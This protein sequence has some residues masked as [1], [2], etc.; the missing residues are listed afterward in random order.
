MAGSNVINKRIFNSCPKE[1]D[2]VWDKK[3]NIRK[4]TFKD[5]ERCRMKN[6]DKYKLIFISVNGNR[7]SWVS[8]Q[9]KMTWR[10]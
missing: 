8:V 3:L 1:N 10:K 6:I 9:Y 7:S 2:F 5:F 4:L